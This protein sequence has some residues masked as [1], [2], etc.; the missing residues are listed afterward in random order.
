MDFEAWFQRWLT[1][2]PLKESTE[3]DRASYTAEVMT[4]VKALAPAPTESMVKGWRRQVVWGWPRL[5][6][7]AATALA[8]LAFVVFATTRHSGGRLAREIGRETQLL[9]ALEGEGMAPLN[10]NDVEALTHDLETADTLLLAESP[11]RD[12]QWI[13]QTLQLLDELDEEVPVDASGG[14][15]SEQDWI[16]E[17]EVLDEGEPSASS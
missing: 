8:G 6:L 17:L 16:Q 3:R 12:E 2:H 7:V 11:P 5:A 9:A 1:R 13:E 15:S 10:G 4:I 14:D